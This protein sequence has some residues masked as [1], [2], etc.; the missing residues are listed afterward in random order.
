MQGKISRNNTISSCSDKQRWKTL[1]KQEHC[2]F[3]MVGEPTLFYFKY[4]PYMFLEKIVLVISIE[5]V[6]LLNSNYVSNILLNI[7]HIL[8]HLISY[9]PMM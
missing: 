8:C 5:S 7:L 4:K 9:S 2:T 3:E 6:N 1:C